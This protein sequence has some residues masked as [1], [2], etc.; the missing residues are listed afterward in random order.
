MR[1]RLIGPSNLPNFPNFPPGYRLT[2]FRLTD[3]PTAYNTNPASRAGHV[4]EGEGVWVRE[5]V[6]L[7]RTRRF[8][9]PYLRRLLEIG[10]TA[11]LQHGVRFLGPIDRLP[12]RA[13]QIVGLER[14]DPLPAQHLAHELETRLELR[15]D[16]LVGSPRGEPTDVAGA[17]A[18]TMTWITGF[19]ERAFRITASVANKSGLSP[20]RCAP[21]APP[22][23]PARRARPHLRTTR[24]C[25]DRAGR[26]RS[27]G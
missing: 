21:S 25:L 1:Y 24:R 8:L 13:H 17:G 6:G 15:L 16:D 3:F 2:D 18:R 23:S 14:I 7:G 22:R 5:A 12:P 20:R 27:P 19:S 26:A 4:R 10:F 11:S 9:A